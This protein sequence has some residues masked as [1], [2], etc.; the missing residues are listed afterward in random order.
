MP[1]SQNYLLRLTAEGVAITC[2]TCG[3]TSSHW[4]DVRNRY[5]G[6]C[7]KFLGTGVLAIWTITERPHDYVAS[8]ELV[9]PRGHSHLTE[10]IVVSK[11][12]LELRI[13][14]L[15]RNLTMIPRNVPGE[16][17]IIEVWL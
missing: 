3:H 15:A 5:C 12:L 4:E 9:G 8:K 17:R 10:E 16:P 6:R 11:T 13:E 14:M 1:L 2:H 7:K